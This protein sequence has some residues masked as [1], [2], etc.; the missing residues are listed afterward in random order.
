MGRG[1]Y[2]KLLDSLVAW[3][4]TKPVSAK[5]KSDAGRLLGPFLDAYI[6]GRSDCA[7]NTIKN[8]KQCRRELCVYFGERHPLVAINAADAER[9]KRAMLARVVKPASNGGPAR[10]MAVATASKHVKRA[11]TMFAEAVSDKL[12]EA[13]PFAKLKGGSECNPKRLRIINSDVATKVLEACPDADWRLIFSLAR[14]GGLRVPSEIRIRWTDVDWHQGRFRIDS[15][16]TGVRHC[17]LFPELLRA[18]QESWEVAEDGAEFCLSRHRS[19]E[20]LRTQFGRILAS[21]GIDPWPRLFQNLRSTRRTELQETY[22]NHVINAWLGQSTKV[23]EKHYLK[24]TDE[25]WQRAVSFVS[26]AAPLISNKYMAIRSPRRHSKP[27]ART[28]RNLAEFGRRNK[29]GN[30][31]DC[32]RASGTV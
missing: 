29:G 5:A 14:F 8:F 20:N 7:L 23:A 3:G 10:T 11:K 9:W 2:R 27:V 22:P 13:N 21:D 16:K 17:P 19:S 25:H 28:S 30:R 12:L 31:R 26:L 6:A 1:Y 18:F 4:L 24:E 32:A 15:P